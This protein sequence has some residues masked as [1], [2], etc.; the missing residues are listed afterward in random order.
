MLHTFKPEIRN[1]IAI[2]SR[3][4]PDRPLRSPWLYLE[5]T[6][7]MRTPRNSPYIDL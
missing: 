7:L 1:Y 3:T 6:R 2:I 5:A 4:V